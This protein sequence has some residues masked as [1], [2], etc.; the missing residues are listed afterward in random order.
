MTDRDRKPWWELDPEERPVPLDAG[1]GWAVAD[2]A[3][4]FVNLEREAIIREDTEPALATLTSTGHDQR[5]VRRRTLTVSRSGLAAAVLSLAI[6][7]L[8]MFAWGWNQG[9]AL[10]ADLRHP[11]VG[12]EPAIEVD[13][14]P[15]TE[16]RRGHASLKDSHGGKL[17]RKGD[18]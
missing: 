10:A 16:S 11:S 9:A 2:D 5:T 14:A 4:L 8:A 1:G 15:V 3:E 7:C 12:E 13:V 17:N 6:G 18:S